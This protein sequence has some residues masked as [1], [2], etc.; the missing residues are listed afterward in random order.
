MVEAKH[1]KATWFRKL[2]CAIRGHN[3][4]GWVY[5][6]PASKRKKRKAYRST[7]IYCERCGKRLDYW[8]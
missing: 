5:S 7:R 1:P 3:A 4:Q 6:T 8:G 2:I